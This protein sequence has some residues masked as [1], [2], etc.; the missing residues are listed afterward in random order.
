MLEGDKTR[1]YNIGA[2][3]KIT[4]R[5][6]AITDGN[7]KNYGSYDTSVGFYLG[8]DSRDNFLYLS[9]N[10]GSGLNDYKPVL[11]SVTTIPI[12]SIEGVDVVG[13]VNLGFNQYEL[14]KVIP[15]IKR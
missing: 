5:N 12:S 14:E 2:V 11:K 7:G 10:L 4:H 9:A 1:G 8:R 15:G 6:S 13:Q 3:L